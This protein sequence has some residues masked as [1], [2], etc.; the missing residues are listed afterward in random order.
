MTA[1]FYIVDQNTDRH[2]GRLGLLMAKNAQDWQL[3]FMGGELISYHFSKL[4]PAPKHVLSPCEHL[5]GENV[6]YDAELT[7]LK[8]KQA[9][10]FGFAQQPSNAEEETRLDDRITELKQYI[11]ENEYQITLHTEATWLWE[12]KQTMA[13]RNEEKAR[14]A[15]FSGAVIKS[16]I[17]SFGEQQPLFPQ[18]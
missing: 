7:Y 12:A 16:P 5:R 11:A 6:H 17:T 15:F 8:H 13:G 2:C 4:K 9:G 14:E 18:S 10:T 1:E 3:M